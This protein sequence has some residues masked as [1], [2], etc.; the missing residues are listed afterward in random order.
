VQS[1]RKMS[2]S[3]GADAET[4]FTRKLRCAILHPNLGSHVSLATQEHL[5]S[6]PS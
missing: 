5:G 1:S 2:Y 6:T 3:L 4:Q